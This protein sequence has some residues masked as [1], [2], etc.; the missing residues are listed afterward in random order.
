MQIVLNS[1]ILPNMVATGFQATVRTTDQ[2]NLQKQEQ[3]KM[4]IN[5]I[6]K[7]LKKLFLRKLSLQQLYDVKRENF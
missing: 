7:K 2:G 5:L 4:K 1:G 6:K 3:P